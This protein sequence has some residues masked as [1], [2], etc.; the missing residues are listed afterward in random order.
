MEIPLMLAIQF[1][2]SFVMLGVGALKDLVDNTVSNAF[3]VVYGVVAFGV[4]F[5]EYGLTA[6]FGVH[7]IFTLLIGVGAYVAWRLAKGRL[8]GADAKAIMA[9]GVSLPVFSFLVLGYAGLFALIYLF[10]KSMKKTGNLRDA[11][12]IK[13]PFLPFMFAGVCCV[14]LAMWLS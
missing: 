8:G 12:K 1:V 10:F 5:Y 3:W 14:G 4:A 13:A 11:L 2:L 6:L 9:L 7:L